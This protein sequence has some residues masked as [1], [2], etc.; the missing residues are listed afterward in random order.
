MSARAE[1]GAADT[2]A[3]GAEGNG[4]L[5]VAGHAH[6]Q[7]RQARLAGKLLQQGEMRAGVLVDRRD[8]HQALDRETMRVPAS[9]EERQ[10]LARIDARLLRLRAGVD[11]DVEA[12]RLALPAH[13]PGEFSGDLLAVDG[14]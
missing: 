11:L 13:L 10:R 2:N 7:L 14:L 4:R 6:R 1:N 5:V 12:W 3:G 9:G 8:A